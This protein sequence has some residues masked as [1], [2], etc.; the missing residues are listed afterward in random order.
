VRVRR[1]DANGHIG[2]GRHEYL[3]GAMVSKKSP[4]RKTIR[5]LRSSRWI[6]RPCWTGPVTLCFQAKSSSFW[7]L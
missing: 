3:S 2:C 5:R 7:N 4:L 1:Y 6:G